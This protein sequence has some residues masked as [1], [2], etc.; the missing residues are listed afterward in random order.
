MSRLSA[1]LIVGAALSAT[2]GLAHAEA[3]ADQTKE[4]R[5]AAQLGHLPTPESVGQGQ[6]YAQL[7][8]AAALAQAEAQDVLGHEPDCLLA[9]RRAEQMLEL[10]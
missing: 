1:V 4:L 6:T 9:A 7:S 3:C 8:F 10:P 5:H 2:T